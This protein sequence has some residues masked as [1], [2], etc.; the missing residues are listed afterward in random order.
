[1]AFNL[2]FDSADRHAPDGDWILIRDWEVLKHILINNKGKCSSLRINYCGQIERWVD[3]VDWL[4]GIMESENSMSIMPT[5]VSN[6]DVI[7]DHLKAINDAWRRQ[8]A[9]A[10]IILKNNFAEA[11]WVIE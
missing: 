7:K 3:F 6:S 2:W 11:G 9:V 8:S 5:F 4:T 10:H 1:M